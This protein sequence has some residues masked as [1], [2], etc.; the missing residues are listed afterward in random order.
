MEIIVLVLEDLRWCWA[1]GVTAEIFL[2]WSTPYFKADSTH[3]K[4]AT[5]LVISLVLTVVRHKFHVRLS[6]TRAR[7]VEQTGSQ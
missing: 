7:S 4:A 2:C 6:R 5:R 1:E 3:R